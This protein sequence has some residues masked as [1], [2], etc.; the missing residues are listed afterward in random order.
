MQELP[1]T[2]LVPIAQAPNVQ[3][4]QYHVHTFPAVDTALTPGFPQAPPDA[5]AALGEFDL[6]P[7]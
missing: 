2:G 3:A 4:R 7:S 5:G 6:K 1:A